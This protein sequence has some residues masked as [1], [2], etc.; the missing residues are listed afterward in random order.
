MVLSSVELQNSKNIFI[1]CCRCGTSW[2]LGTTDISHTTYHRR[3]THHLPQTSD[4]HLPQTSHTSSITDV[5]NIACC[6]RL[7][8]HLSQ[9]PHTSLTV[10]VLHRVHDKSNLCFS[11]NVRTGIP[12]ILVK[13]PHGKPQTLSKLCMEA[14]T[15]IDHNMC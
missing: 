6:R 15:N 11:T 1:T 9:T 7:T 10:G 12:G 14:H 3:L 4:T 8:H 5:S 13:H 2:H